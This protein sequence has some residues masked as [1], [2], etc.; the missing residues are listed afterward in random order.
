MRKWILCWVLL[1]VVLLSFAGV[2]SCGCGDDDSSSG[3]EQ[4][5][6]DNIAPSDD[7][8]SCYTCGITAECTDAFGP[9]WAC[10]GGCCVEVGKTT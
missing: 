5:D 10:Y 1:L 2:I 6:D 8:E 9:G 7:D 3:S 4:I